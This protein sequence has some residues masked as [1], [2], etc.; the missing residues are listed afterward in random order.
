M[1]LALEFAFVVPAGVIAIPFTVVE[2]DEELAL[3]K[4]KEAKLAPFEFNAVS[5]SARILPEVVTLVI[6]AT[7]DVWV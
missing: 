2:V 1:V 6:D 7:P 4:V 3:V 5:D